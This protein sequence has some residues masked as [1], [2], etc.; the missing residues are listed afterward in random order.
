MASTVTYAGPALQIEG[1]QVADVSPGPSGIRVFKGIPY[2]APPTGELRWKAA[3]PVKTW[4]GVRTASEWGPRCV[5]SNRLGDLDPLNKRMDEDC[6]YLNVWTPAKLTDSALPVMVWIHGGSNLNG[7]GSQ[8]EYDGSNLARKGVVVVT[9]NYRLDIFGFLAHPELS[10]ESGT[11]SSGNYGLLDQIA[12]LKWVQRNIRAFGG[13]P[14]QVAIFGESAGA[15]DVSLLMASPLAKGLFMR[16]IGESG[17]A[18]TPI[19]AFGPKPLQIGEQDGVKFAQSMGA[20]SIS[21]LRAKSAQE[22]L[23]AAIKNPINYGFGVVDDYVVPEH[24]ALIYSQGKQNDVP[25]LVGWNADEGSYFGAR[26]K[27]DSPSYAERIRAQFKDN[28]DKV[29]QLYPPGSTPEQERASFTALL[30]DEVIAYGGWAWSQRAATSGK[31]PVFRYYFTRRPPG[32]PTEFSVNPIA[33]PGVYHF[34][35]IYYVFDNLDV[36]KDWPWSPEDRRLAEIMSSYWTNFAKTGD[37]NGPGLPRW[38]AYMPTREGQV[39]Q[40]G[41]TSNMQPQPHPNRY[42]FWDALY[43]K[44]G[45][46]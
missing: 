21:D 17:G 24:P 2:A 13:D 31:S 22:L 35:E 4:D 46:K 25:L 30:G 38:D 34:A 40:L 9:F 3:Q 20:H 32:A 37:P 45:P 14:S 15:F 10:K 8:P 5:Q 12:A 29:L 39:M 26:I 42:E 36:M 33:A 44:I 27:L 6:L 19:P 23:D 41:A 7:A 1:G 43:A 16:A 11:N 18:L 28:A